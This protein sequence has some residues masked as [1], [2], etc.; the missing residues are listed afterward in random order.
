MK[1]KVYFSP[2][3]AGE[4][5]QSVCAKIT[6]L[7][8]KIG[9]KKLVKKD[10]LVA[11]KIHM[12]EGNKKMFISPHF[13]RP[14]AELV[15]E[16]GGKP[17]VTDTNTLYTGRRSNA[18]DHLMMAYENGFT[19]DNLG[20]P[21]IIGDGLV[22]ENQVSRE[23]DF[24]PGRKSMVHISGLASR[25]DVIIGIGHCTGHLLTGYGGALKNIAMGLSGP[26]G[27]LDQHS[28]VKP[29]IM[30]D[31]CVACELCIIHCPAK[32]ISLRNNKSFIDAAVCI[33][34]GECYAVCPNKAVKVNKWQ[35]GPEAVQEKIALYA[36]AI[37]RD[38]KACYINFATNITKNCDCMGEPETA[39][40]N[41]AGILASLDPVALDV[42]SVQLI[43][44]QAGKDIFRAAW[45]DIDYRVQFR[46]AER[47]GAGNIDYELVKL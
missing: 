2:T 15:Q 27:K 12:G 1:S 37:L 16:S 4:P 6:E 18:P 11:L 44:Q 41:D 31:D 26:G 29:E 35:G 20:C 9:L 23:I 19:I 32:A 3:S 24:R 46:A 33:G 21:V 22:G 40:A 25:A 14:I 8:A 45:P 30:P 42:A 13:V 10:E 43:N 38:K 7:C 34:C 5:R 17:F 47:L 39:M 36:T 28:G